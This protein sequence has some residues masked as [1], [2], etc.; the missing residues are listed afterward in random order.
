M[1]YCSRWVSSS[2]HHVRTEDLLVGV[3]EPVPIGLTGYLRKVGVCDV[4]V[5]VIHLIDI[6]RGPIKTNKGRFQ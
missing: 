4:D 5:R 2:S 3:H 6:R 1:W